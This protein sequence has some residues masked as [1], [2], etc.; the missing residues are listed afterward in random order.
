MDRP[1]ANCE[2]E[3]THWSMVVSS[4]E[5][6]SGI[7]RQS[8]GKL[9]ELYWYP[10][11]VFLRRKGFDP[12]ASSDLVQGFFVELIDKEFLDAVSPDKGRFR[13]FLKSAIKRYTAKQLEKQSAQKRGGDRTFFSLDV[14]DAEQKYQME[15]V[16]NWSAE[17]LFDR[18][19]GLTVLQQALTALA[20][21]YE[22]KK[23]SELYSALQKTLSGQQMT[24]EEYQEI[25]DRFQMTANAVKV[26]ALRLR[27]KYRDMIREIV[28]QTVTESDRVSDEIDELFNAL[29]G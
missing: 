16:E 26:T 23:K 24:Q 2:F 22:S 25:G 15:P 28:A 1:K 14:Q 9:C 4:R 3:T 29:S 21:E 8:L 19:W 5:K 6:D 20:T 11:F 13:W 7:R 12:D 17:K 18:Q 10:L 27:Q